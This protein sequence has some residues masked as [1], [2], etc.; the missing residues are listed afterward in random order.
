MGS[1][2]KT[3]QARRMRTFYLP[4]AFLFLFL[5]LSSSCLLKPGGT[6][7]VESNGLLRG[8]RD[9]GVKMKNEEKEHVEITQ[10][11][12]ANL[13]KGE[14]EEFNMELNRATGESLKDTTETTE[15]SLL[16]YIKV[17]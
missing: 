3:I 4:L 16:T 8:K 7:V 9:V 6:V 10:T 14:K 2:I 11:P 12:A 1:S 15:A 13:L 17:F 5:A